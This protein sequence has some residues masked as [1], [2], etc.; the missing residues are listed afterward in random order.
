MVVMAVGAVD[1]A[2]A[3]ATGLKELQGELRALLNSEES[4]THCEVVMDTLPIA[5]ASTAIAVRLQQAGSKA[6]STALEK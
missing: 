5:G 3:I 4:T 6:V 1:T 2:L